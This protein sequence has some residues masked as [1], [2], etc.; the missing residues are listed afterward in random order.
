MKLYGKL[1]GE[2]IARHLGR[3]PVGAAPRPAAG[4]EHDSPPQAVPVPA[5]LAGEAVQRI[6]AAGLNLADA[7][8]I[9]GQGAADDL[10]AVAVDDL[11]H[12]IR[13]IWAMMYGLR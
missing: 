5:A 7:R 8:A 2:A 10:L 13:D 11:D 1:A 12:A 4:E 9:V 3:S 6:F